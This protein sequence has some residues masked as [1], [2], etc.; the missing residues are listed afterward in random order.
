V[1]LIAWFRGHD[2]GHLYFD[3]LCKSLPGLP[4]Y[5]R[6]VLQEA[7]ADLFGLL[8]SVN[9]VRD[10]PEICA[11]PGHAVAVFLAE[12]L[13]YARRDRLLFP[14]AASG[15]LVLNSYLTEGVL[16]SE[17]EVFE[18]YDMPKLLSYSEALLTT[19]G[20]R[21][22]SGDV[23]SVERLLDRRCGFTAGGLEPY[24]DSF[25]AKLYPAQVPTE[26]D[27][28]F[29]TAEAFCLHDAQVRTT[30]GRIAESR[31]VCRHM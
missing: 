29:E 4:K 16:T 8:T 17:E 18:V 28:L 23:T 15:W 20:E 26:V 19:L 14:D 13:R 10:Y 25:N 11:E 1:H 2:I 9:F 3:H 7:L 22:Q 27:A 12:A 24:P 6:Y 30:R 31:Y 21:V 5:K